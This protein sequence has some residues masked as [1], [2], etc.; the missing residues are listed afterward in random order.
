MYVNALNAKGAIQLSVCRRSNHLNNSK[1]EI[2]FVWRTIHANFDFEWMFKHQ[3]LRVLCQFRLFCFSLPLFT[4]KSHFTMKTI[5][6]R[7]DEKMKSKLGHSA[8]WSMA[9]DLQTCTKEPTEH[10]LIAHASCGAYLSYGIISYY[11]TL[12]QWHYGVAA[13]SAKWQYTSCKFTAKGQSF[14]SFIKCVYLTISLHKDTNAHSPAHNIR[15]SIH[16][17]NL[18]MDF[19]SWWPPVGCVYTLFSI[20]LTLF[21]CIVYFS[22]DSIIYIRCYCIKIPSVCM[23]F[24]VSICVCVCVSE[25]V[26]PVCLFPS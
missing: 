6:K 3:K 19:F 1:R 5:I 26:F 23:L 18:F 16:R 21:F 9:V 12:K 2:S 22:V 13:A 14:E 4:Y 25:S 24:T 8:F 17:R 15:T 7:S 11:C 20:S 10:W